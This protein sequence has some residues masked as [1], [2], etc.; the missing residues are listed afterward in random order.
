MYINQNDFL[1]P[2]NQPDVS[3]VMLAD[4]TF[5]SIY[6]VGSLNEEIFSDSIGH[7]VNNG[8]MT[9]RINYSASDSLTQY[10]EIHGRLQIYRWE[11]YYKKWIS[12]G[13][14]VN[15]EQNYVE[16][17]IDRTGIFT[18]L[19]NQDT[20]I[21]FVEV[22]V[23][24]QELTQTY[25][26]LSNPDYI[27]VGYIAKDGIISYTI[28]DMNGIDI[29]D[30][31]V[32]LFLDDGTNVNP[33]SESEFS[34]SATYNK[35]TEVP[36]KYQLPDLSKGQYS[37]ILNCHDVNGNPKN[38]V[39]EFTVNSKFDILNFANYPNPVKSN[40]LYPENEGRT[41]FTYVLTD[42]AD[43]VYIKIYTVSGRL[44]KTFRDLPTSV[45]YHEFP[46]SDIG[47]DC[48]DNK[49]RYLANGVY[50]YRITAIKGNK[51]IQKTQK[52]AILK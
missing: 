16:T 44:V 35:L 30:K 6:E 52:M 31:K 28:F 47:W 3:A 14:I 42:D 2:L 11:D 5:S 15:P 37:L 39:F 4:S 46:R 18:I 19:N 41:R 23:E 43:E 10:W 21:P 34:L 48:R 25:A 51:R 33:V 40:T 36:V 29:F 17:E 45:G 24:D 8:K 7:Y 20:T 22:N 13:G 12:V 50:F 49:G 1:E 9:V 38:M 32:T 26:S 27:Q